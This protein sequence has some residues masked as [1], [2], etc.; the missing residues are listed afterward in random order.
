MIYIAN[1]AIGGY[2]ITE[3]FLT[4]ASGINY[5]PHNLILQILLSG[6]LI[7]LTLFLIVY[8]KMGIRIGN[9]KCINSNLLS[10]AIFSYLIVS[11]TETTMNT[12]YLLFIISCNLKTIESNKREYELFDDRGELKSYEADKII[13]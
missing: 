8:T 11:L 7:S 4:A 5:S 1:N 9:G 12:Q 3:K 13:Y 6:G 10:I 2:G